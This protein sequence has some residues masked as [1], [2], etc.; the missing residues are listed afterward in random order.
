MKLTAILSFILF[1]SAANANSGVYFAHIGGVEL[2]YSNL[3]VFYEYDVAEARKIFRGLKKELDYA[4]GIEPFKV[5]DRPLKAVNSALKTLT[6]VTGP[7]KNREAEVRDEGG[8]EGPAEARKIVYSDLKITKQ[9]FDWDFS[10][11]KRAL[12]DLKNVTKRKYNET[13]D[14]VDSYEKVAWENLLSQ[15]STDI[16]WHAENIESHLRLLSPTARLRNAKF[17][18]KLLQE[19]QREARRLAQR[20]FGGRTRPVLKSPG[21]DDIPIFVNGTSYF[22]TFDAPLVNKD[23]KLQLFKYKSVPELIEPLGYVGLLEDEGYLAIDDG[24]FFVLTEEYRGCDHNRDTPICRA[25]RTTIFRETGKIEHWVDGPRCLSALFSRNTLKSDQYCQ[26]AIKT[27]SSVVAAI[28]PD[29]F[30]LPH[31]DAKI[32]LLCETKFHSE[33]K[34]EE[35]KGQSV[36]VVKIPRRCRLHQEFGI[37]VNSGQVPYEEDNDILYRP[38]P[39]HFMAALKNDPSKRKHFEYANPTNVNKIMKTSNEDNKEDNFHIYVAIAALAVYTTLGHLISFAN[40]IKNRPQKKIKTAN[41]HPF[42]PIRENSFSLEQPPLNPTYN[43][44]A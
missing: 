42:Q 10:E 2:K 6:H 14:F 24:L 38:F 12:V 35:H 23:Y 25:P 4:M 22:A 20:K 27:E 34:I 43:V 21:M 17:P 18:E 3:H 29:S 5:Y 13:E 7:V 1:F 15:A 8:D 26:Y 40:M 16:Q 11:L 9:V 32:T 44:V 28:M 37:T 39:S 30:S 41:P 36:D 19:T 33:E 31:S